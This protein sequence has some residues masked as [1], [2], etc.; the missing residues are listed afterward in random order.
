MKKKTTE[1]KILI[2][3]YEISKTGKDFFK[4]ISIEIL[5]QIVKINKK[6]LETILK[7]LSRS[8]FLKRG[9]DCINLTQKSISLIEDMLG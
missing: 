9:D 6:K 7:Q 2:K 8:G 1:E 4:E 5:S 3:V